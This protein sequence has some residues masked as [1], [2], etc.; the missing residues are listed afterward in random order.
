MVFFSFNFHY[1]PWHCIFLLAY[2]SNAPAAAFDWTWSCSTL[3]CTRSI[4]FSLDRYKAYLHITGRQLLQRSALSNYVGVDYKTA[5]INQSI[6]YKYKQWC[7]KLKMKIYFLIVI[8]FIYIL[9]WMRNKRA[10]IHCS[11]VIE[12]LYLLA[13]LISGQSSRDW[14]WL[15]SSGTNV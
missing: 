10:V 13:S 4:P 11:E 14:T 8:H 5:N 2:T 9:H 1:R 7:D 12:S 15:L 6:K 3:G